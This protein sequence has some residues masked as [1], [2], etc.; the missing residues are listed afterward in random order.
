M[1]PIRLT[2][3]GFLS[4]GKP[5][6]ECEAV[7]LGV[8]LE[9]VYHRLAVHQAIGVSLLD[10]P[11]HGARGTRKRADIGGD[12]FIADDQTV[13]KTNGGN[14]RPLAGKVVG[15]DGGNVWVRVGI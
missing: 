2:V 7:L 11:A 1:N 12:C 3:E 15:L 9:N 10:H 14:T 6:A 13:A 4:F 8:R 5:A